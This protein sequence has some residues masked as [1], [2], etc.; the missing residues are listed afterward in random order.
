MV[1]R[2]KGRDRKE[3]RK[4][5]GYQGRKEGKDRT[6]QDSTEGRTGNIKKGTPRQDRKE[7]SKR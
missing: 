6:G 7:E 3:G 4:E 2:T 5:G 1:G